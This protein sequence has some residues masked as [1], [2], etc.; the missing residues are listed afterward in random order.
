METLNSLLEPAKS[1]QHSLGG[2]NFYPESYIKPKLASQDGG[3]GEQSKPSESGNRGN[4]K[5]LEKL[6]SSDSS[7]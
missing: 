7:E 1:D 5:L 3:V 4:C 6:L 2:A